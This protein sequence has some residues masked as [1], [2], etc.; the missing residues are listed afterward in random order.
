M[1]EQ[2]LTVRMFIDAYIDKYGHNSNS[3]VTE[4]FYESGFI[5]RVRERIDEINSREEDV[6][7]DDMAE[8]TAEIVQSYFLNSK[9]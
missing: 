5:D 6:T 8:I 3:R 9:W 1:H 2:E 4:I 7:E